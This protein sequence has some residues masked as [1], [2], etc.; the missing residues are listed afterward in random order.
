MEVKPRVLT[1][2]LLA[3]F[4]SLALSAQTGL[5]G[6]SVGG[7]FGSLKE[8]FKPGG[9]AKSLVMSGPAAYAEGEM[10]FGRWYGNMGLGFIIAPKVSLGGD[11]YDTTGYSSNFGLDFTALGIGYLYPLAGKLSAGGGLGF[12]VSAPT[13]EPPNGDTSKLGFGGYYGLIGATIAPRLRY[14]LS[15]SLALTLS[16]PIG[17]DFSAMSEEVVILGED[18]G[19]Q[20]KAEVSPAGLDPQFKG[21]S[22]GVYATIGYFSKL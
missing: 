10:D 3:S 20:S 22:F 17:L 7:G 19:T 21:L 6:V 2:I 15:D 18:T 13:M 8:E 4:A 12:H 16:L 9:T 11:S 1:A 5:W 14:A